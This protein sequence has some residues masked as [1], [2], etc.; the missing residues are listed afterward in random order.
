M[1]LLIPLLLWIPLVFNYQVSSQSRGNQ[2]LDSA[3]KFI[4]LAPARLR[5]GTKLNILLEAHSLS[6]PITVKVIVYTFEK[7]S[8]L[9]RD[10]AILNSAN[11]YSDLKTIEINPN[12]LKKILKNSVRLVVEF[13]SFHKA[14]KIITV[15][16]R[17]G[18]IFIQTDK[19]VYNPGDTVHYRVFVS[20]HEF[21]AFNTNISL[22][23]QNPDGDVVHISSNTSVSDGIL[24]ESYP[25]P[26]V[27]KEGKWKVVAK[28]DDVEENTFSAG[29]HVKKYVL[30]AF[31]VTLTPKKPY[32]SLQEDKL[33]VEVRARYLYG[34]QVQG[35]AHVL[36]GIDMNGQKRRITSLKQ[37]NDL[38]GGKVSLSMAEMKKVFPDTKGLLGNSVYVKASVM[39]SG[40]DLVEAEKSG[41]K[42]VMSPYVLSIRDTPKYFKPGLPLGIVVTVSNQ[43]GS[44]APNIPVKLNF[45]QKPIKTHRGTIRVSINMP[46]EDKNQMLKVET[47]LPGVN[48]ENQ[49]VQEMTLEPYLSFD[50]YSKNYLHISVG[51][52]QVAV[53][54]SLNIK[55]H[56]K[57][58]SPEH[59]KLVKQLTYV[60]LNKGKIITASRVDVCQNDTNIPLLVTTEMLPSFRLVAYYMLPWQLKAEV[61]ADSVFVDVE[62][63]CVGSLSSGPVEGE[64]LNSYSPRRTFKFQVKGDP[65]A[66]VSLVAVD[67]AIFLL[68]KNCLMQRKVWEAVGQG[69]MG[70]TA[71]GGRDSMG[72]FSD[73][74]LMF[75]SSTGP[76]TY[77]GSDHC[78][79]KSRRKRS[80]KQKATKLEQREKLEEG[81]SDES[82][83]RCCV[84]GMREIPMHYSC[85]RRSLSKDRCCMLAFLHCCV[86]YRGEELD[87]VTRPQI[88]EINSCLMGHQGPKGEQ[89][90]REPQRPRPLGPNEAA[91]PN[92]EQVL[93]EL[94]SPRLLGPNGAAGP[95]WDAR[96]KGEQVLREH[97]D[98]RPLGPDEAAGPRWAAG[99]NGEQVLREL[100]SPRLLGPNG[101]AGPSWDARPKGE[102]VLREHQ[103]PRPLGP[104]EAAGPRWAAGPNGEQVLR[105]L[106]G[107]RVLGPRWAAGAAGAAGP[108]GKQVSRELQGRR[109]RRAQWGAGLKGASRPKGPRAQGAAGPP[110][111]LAP[112]GLGGSQGPRRK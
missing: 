21:Q 51:A 71:G 74:G 72:V 104:D 22:E 24:S 94:Q 73:A 112:L 56:I 98:P 101:A 82:L 2:T 25:L 42:I 97:Q 11:R 107:P 44:P 33:E 105:E 63:Q 15:S 80:L 102:Q 48:A 58:A 76:S 9:M 10:S 85:P 89:V 53:G 111:G 66:K 64:K 57:T 7:E 92:G 86:E 110:L 1:R 30:P 23:I 18:Y 81:F 50:G 37:L 96:P 17:S 70:C 20:N 83:R 69:D 106:Q 54:S 35:V 41:I 19:P 5:L 78:S 88:E 68:S 27:H 6:E 90:L 38:N 43:D 93:R 13:G 91:G 40:S 100:Q 59:R 103:D 47:A 4:M 55:L 109:G 75:Y 31:N 79:K 12:L 46:D 61:V 62:N 39:S 26:T 45:L 65:G 3:P 95:S 52:K 87:N 8:V 14:E 108:N 60:V 84:D 34:E 36:F 16:F 77:S 32:F 99:P 67:N 28:L 29:F 49:A